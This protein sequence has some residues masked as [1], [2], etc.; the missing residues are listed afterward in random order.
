MARTWQSNGM[1]NLSFTGVDQAEC[2][3]AA[4]LFELT[5]EE[6]PPKVIADATK[7][8]DFAVGLMERTQGADGPFTVTDGLADAALDGLEVISC[9]P[10]HQ[11]HE[12]AGLILTD[13][14]AD[15]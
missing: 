4:A 15:P 8:L 13:S 10:G 1:T 9:D 2:V 12:V 6:Q 11:W 5:A 3:R 14:M 7:H